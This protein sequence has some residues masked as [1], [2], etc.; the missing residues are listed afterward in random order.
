VHS[1]LE[2]FHA[3]DE[4]ERMLGEH[5]AV[6]EHLI[7]GERDAAMRALEQHVKRSLGPNLDFLKALGPVPANTLPPYLVPIEAKA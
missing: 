1:T 3:A 2:R 7:E 5:R 6:L 4:I